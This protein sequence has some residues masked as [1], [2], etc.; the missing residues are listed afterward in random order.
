MSDQSQPFN[1]LAAFIVED[2][3]IIAFMIEDMLGELG[4]AKVVHA[5]SVPK[6]L[7]QV[8]QA[9]PDVAILDVNVA[10]TPVYAVAEKLK[11]RRVPFAFASGYGRGGLPPEWS[12][13][14]VIQKPFDLT[15]LREGLS[16][17]LGRGG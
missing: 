12:T 5:S 15:Q 8:E 6:A 9:Q 16:T 2:E 10:G 4:F 1:G 17:C 14:T 11:E 7:I 13:A 3:A